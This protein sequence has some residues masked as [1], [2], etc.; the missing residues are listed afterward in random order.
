MVQQPLTFLS[1]KLLKAKNIITA[2]SIQVDD[3]TAV[4]NFGSIPANLNSNCKCARA[5]RDDALA[6]VL[7]LVH[8]ARVPERRAVLCEEAHRILAEGPSPSLAPRWRTEPYRRG[9]AST[10]KAREEAS[11]ATERR[12]TCRPKGWR[13]L[14]EATLS[15]TAQRSRPNGPAGPRKAVGRPWVHGAAMSW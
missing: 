11:A 1:T 5:L 7:E 8:V 12:E 6:E 2:K 9:G 10:R 3:T 4:S 14:G 15:P 13:G